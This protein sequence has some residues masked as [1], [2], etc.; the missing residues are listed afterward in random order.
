M[1]SPP[2]CADAQQALA[3]IPWQLF[4][5]MSKDISPRYLRYKVWRLHSEI[6]ASF[7]ADHDIRYAGHPP[8]AVDHEGFLLSEF[9]H[10][11]IHTNG[12]YGAL[13]LRQMRELA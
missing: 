1:E 2:P 12:R 9:S 13:L 8:Q 11:G 3:H 5:G 7:C 10:D 4:P 6:V